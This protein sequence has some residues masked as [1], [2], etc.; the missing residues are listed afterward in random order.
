MITAEQRITAR[1]RVLYTTIVLG[2]I[3]LS[4]AAASAGNG[5]FKNSQYNFCVSVRFNANAAQLALIQTAF[6]NASQVL[7]DATDGQQ[8][9][10]TVTIVNNSGASQAAEYWVNSGTGRAYATYGKYGV[11]GEHINVYFGSNFQSLNGPD[12]DAYTVAHEFAHHAYGLADEYSGPGIASGA[13]CAVRPDTATLNYC[14]M[15][16]YFSRGGRSFPGALYTLNEFCVSGNH[17]PNKNTYQESINHESCWKTIADHP[18]RG[19]NAPAGLPGGAPPAPHTV[20]FESG[21]GGLRVM[22]VI[23]RSGSMSAENRLGLAKQ[24]AKLFVNFLNT[25]DSVGVTSFDCATQIDFPLTTI[26]GSG[27]KTAAKAAIDAISLGGST[28]IGGGIQ[29]ALN[30]LT[31]QPEHSCNDIIVLLTDGDHNC[32][33]A[34]E[35]VIPSLQDNQVTALTVGVGAGIS[36]S[37]QS[38]LQNVASQTGGK[39]FSISNSFSLVRVFFQLLLE[40]RIKSNGLLMHEPLAVASGQTR[41]IPVNVEAGAASAI[42]G[43]GIADPSDD[44]TLSLRSPSGTVITMADGTGGNPNIQFNSEAN[45]KAFQI[46]APESGNWTIVVTTGIITTGDLDLFASAEHDGVKLSASLTKDTLVY[47]EVAQIQAT[48]TFGGENVVGASVT[49]TVTRPDGSK[50][51]LTLFDDGLGAHG[52]SVPGDG[53]YSASFSQYRGDGTYSFDLMVA[54]QNGMTYG[55]EDIFSSEASNAKPVPAFT[56]MAS[57]TAI[58]TGVPAAVDADMSVTITDLRDPVIVGDEITYHLVVTNNGPGNATGVSV[59]DTL[60]SSSTFVSATPSVGT[61]DPPLNGKILCQI[62]N[63]LNGAMATIDIIVKSKGNPNTIFNRA[64]AA[65]TD[66]DPVPGNSFASEPTRLVGFRSFSFDTPVLTGGCKNPKGKLTFTSPAPAGVL[67][68][69][70]DNSAAIDQIPDVMT[71]GGE[72]FIEV[73]AM[74]SMVN[75]VQVIPITA[76]TMTDSGPRSIKTRLK[77]LPVGVASLT[78]NPNPVQGGNNAVGTVTLTCATTQN[79]VLRVSSNKRVAQP[80]VN[81]VTIPAGQMQ[82]QFNIVTRIKITERSAVFTVGSPQRGFKRATLVV[83]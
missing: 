67:I 37:G 29:A 12:G 72:T 45:S 76:T 10:G 46:I 33:T 35:A 56:R 31:S 77:L 68:H 19:A 62:G 47:P 44:V 13:D 60:P 21:S 17:D 55:G 36:T 14:L 52:D 80:V 27:T 83:N 8:R 51:A 5:T 54:N 74:T 41:E 4:P 64:F 39:Y 11:R 50:V 18:R 16:N 82:A 9:F 49:G 71:V 63:M 57:A 73:T 2:L 79:V 81:V 70:T 48:P 7:A 38:S 30:E 66:N 43:L 61:C 22:I 25:G 24:G 28:N 23:D 34:P 1:K 59:L 42:F 32:G 78:F 53:I 26:T 58:V 3:L 75:A 65:S 6:Q 20:S 69:F 40:S 15:D